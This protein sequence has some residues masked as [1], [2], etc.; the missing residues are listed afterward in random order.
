MHRF[1]RGARFGRFP[2]RRF[3]RHGIP[4]SRGYAYGSQQGQRQSMY[5][6]ILLGKLLQQIGQLEYKPP[7][8]LFL[9]AVNVVLYLDSSLLPFTSPIQDC[10]LNPSLILSPETG[11]TSALSRL[12]LSGFLHGSDMHLYYNM[13][14][15][16]WKGVK[17]EHQLGTQSFLKLCALMLV[18]SHSLV[19]I[20]A[21]LLLE[22]DYPSAYKTCAVGFSAVLFGL[23][24]VLNFYSP[25]MSAIF[26]M[27]VPSKYAAWLE[28]ILIQFMVPNASFLGHLCGLIAG[29][30]YVHVIVGESFSPTRLFTTSQEFEQASQNSSSRPRD[31]SRPAYTYAR[32]T[33][34]EN[35]NA[36]PNS[37]ADAQYEQ[38]LQEALER[39]R[40]TQEPYYSSYEN[41]NAFRQEQNTISSDEIRRRRLERFGNNN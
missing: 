7:V 31:P 26:G 28:L 15:L 13:A 33:A 30:L 35:T 12:F 11:V 41:N 27:S 21:K 24:Y 8:T 39:S 32:G 25:G 23:K 37:G 2:G 19:V 1:P 6:L 20:V 40:Q 36:P 10:C 17:L 34:E 9:M 16:L 5:L 3:G 14:S 22:L 38:E 4:G 29:I 18:I